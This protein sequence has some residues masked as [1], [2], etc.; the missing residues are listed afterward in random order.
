MHEWPDPAV[1]GRLFARLDAVG[2]AGA[3]GSTTTFTDLLEYESSLRTAPDV[4]DAIAV[5]ALA[6]AAADEV[7]ADLLATSQRLHRRLFERGSARQAAEAGRF[8]AR[9]NLVVDPDSPLG[10][11]AYTRPGSIGQAMLE[12]QDFV[13]ASS[14]DLPDLVRQC[15]G[16]W[17]FEHIHPFLDGNGR[18]GRL[19]IPIVLRRKGFTRSTCAFVSEPIYHDTSLY[20][21]GLKSARISGDMMAWTRLMLGFLHQTAMENI[22]RLDR[23]L[24]I[25]A[26]WRAATADARA[27][28]VIHRLVDYALTRPAFTIADA[29]DGIGGSFPAVNNAA[30]RLVDLNVLQVARDTRRDRLFQAPEVL[31]VFDSFRTPSP[32]PTLA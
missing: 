12:W 5:A 21:D 13:N 9:T 23:L 11:F 8:K 19:L 28:S 32:G 17:M 14:P 24:E 18:V 3:E 7:G 16:H 1:V 15:L 29:L 2:S 10:L 22:A 25:R 31:G 6:D 20:V 26:R 4:A 27:N 30:G